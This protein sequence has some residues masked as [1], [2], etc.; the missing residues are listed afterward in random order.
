MN[1]LI[2][3][4]FTPARSRAP[5]PNAGDLTSHQARRRFALGSELQKIRTT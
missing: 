2:A 1:L 4:G 5:S 3:L